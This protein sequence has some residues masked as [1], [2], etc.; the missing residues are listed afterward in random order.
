MSLSTTNS[1]KA[2]VNGQPSFEDGEALE[3]LD[4][5]QGVVQGNGGFTGAGVDSKTTRVVREH[6]NPGGLGLEDDES[7]LEKSYAVGANVETIGFSSHD[8][9]RVL[10]AYADVDADGTD[11]TYQQGDEVGW[12]A[13]G[14]LEVVDGAAVS[15]AVGRIKQEES[16]TLG[17]TDDPTHTLVEFY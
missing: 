17:S 13:N 15:E 5:G 10:L 9:A 11:D 7:P 6:R 8:K 14:Y 12:N 1:V 3:A 2:Q 4:V 16:V